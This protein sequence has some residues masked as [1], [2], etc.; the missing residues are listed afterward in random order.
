MR[1]FLFSVLLVG[2]LAGPGHISG[3]SAPAAADSRLVVGIEVSVGDKSPARLRV[4]SGQQASVGTAES[5]TIGLTPIV[6][7][8]LIELAVVEIGDGNGG[9][10]DI[11][12]TRVTLRLGDAIAAD[13]GIGR[14]RV[15]WIELLRRPEGS[16]G[17]APE[18]PCRVCCVYCDSQWHCAC[19]V[20]TSCG[21]CCCPYACTCSSGDHRMKSDSAARAA[22]NSFRCAAAGALGR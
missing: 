5:G 1:L 15:Q 16:T 14:L 6:R 13:T 21:H 7:G 8:D 11:E 18:E 10:R 2:L 3:W 17:S 12:A 20:Q 9:S 19:D 22:T 4:L